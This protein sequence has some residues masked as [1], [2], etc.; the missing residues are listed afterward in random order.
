MLL[1]HHISVSTFLLKSIDRNRSRQTYWGSF[2]IWCFRTRPRRGRWASSFSLARSRA[3]GCLEW[4]QLSSLCS[5]WLRG[6]KAG[7]PKMKK[8]FYSDES[9]QTSDLVYALSYTPNYILNELYNRPVSSF[10]ST[11]NFYIIWILI[12]A[13]FIVYIFADLSWYEHIT[14]FL[15]IC[16]IVLFFWTC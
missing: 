5:E 8:T 2:L 6:W 3:L 10:W 4:Y 12:M 13:A 11:R 9:W 15:I 7:Q 16:V 1:Q 14:Y